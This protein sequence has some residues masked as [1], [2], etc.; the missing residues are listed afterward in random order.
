MTV[1]VVVTVELF[2][3]N[4]AVLFGKRNL[5]VGINLCF[6]ALYS[7]VLTPECFSCHGFYR[8]V[9]PLNKLGHDNNVRRHR[10]AGIS[11]QND[12]RGTMH[13]EP[14]I[15]GLYYNREFR[16]NLALM[17]IWIPLLLPMQLAAMAFRNTRNPIRLTGRSKHNQNLEDRCF[18]TEE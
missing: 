16:T 3:P 10:A 15:R 11:L 1:T 12:P 8:M 17:D 9:S 5:K 2:Q 18:L 14:W 4:D 7:L 13:I 6:T